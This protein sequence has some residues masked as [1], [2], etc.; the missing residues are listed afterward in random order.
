MCGRFTLAADPADIQI[1]FGLEQPPTLTNR[2]NISLAQLVAVIAPKQDPTKRGLAL[3]K[4]G[5]VPYWSHDGKPGP[6]NA[7]CETVAG[8]SSF[9]DTFRHR[10]CCIPATGFYEWRTR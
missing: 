5:L 1:H 8:L 2:Y 9:S 3:L 7:R 6:I 10:R 4:W